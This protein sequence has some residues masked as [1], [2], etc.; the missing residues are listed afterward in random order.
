MTR[1]LSLLLLLSGLTL[2]APAYAAD[3]SGAATSSPAATLSPRDT[4]QQA[5][6][7]M[8]QRLSAEHERLVKEPD[9]ASKLV[10]QELD[11][12]VDFKRIT[13]LVM[14][15]WFAKASRDQKYRFLDVFKQSL[16][17]T[18]ASGVTLYQGQKITVL[19]MRDGDVKDNRAFVRMEMTT[20]S[21]KK[22]PVSYTMILN[23]GHWQVENLVVNGLNLG[24]TFRAQ[25]ALSA[26]ANKGDLD[27][28]INHWSEQL[29]A[30]QGL[31]KTTKALTEAAK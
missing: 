25:F 7:R 5:V 23:D 29:K 28:V 14:G 22:I 13:R 2:G 11:G 30:S 6:T 18:Y 12:L 3:T 4:I 1:L 31:D 17:D 21:G 16:I 19:P 15:D 27:K 9:Y 10:S 24:K 20:D 26:S 8:T